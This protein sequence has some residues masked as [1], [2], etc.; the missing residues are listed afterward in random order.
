MTALTCEPWCLPTDIPARAAAQFVEQTDVA[1]CI[2][3]ASGIL[4]ALSGRRW[5]GSCTRTDLALHVGCACDRTLPTYADAMRVGFDSVTL[6]TND[7]SRRWVGL[8]LPDYPVTSVAALSRDGDPI[9]L[10]G[11]VLENNRDLMLLPFDRQWPV[12][13]Y[14]A[15]YDYGIAPPDEA[16][17]A[18]GVLAGEFGLSASGCE[19]R[20]PARVTSVTRQGI[21]A[22]VLD[23]LDFL[24]EGRTGIP[25]VDLFLSA[26]NPRSLSSR[27][28]VLSPDLLS[29]RQPRSLA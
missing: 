19:C 20:L 23:P 14:V 22:V 10:A 6:A 2:Q 12:G 4:Y 24:K 13:D 1:A 26:V 25:E 17:H 8:R 5:R 18:A 9:D 7:W 28:Q 29:P 11:V 16:R 3:L 27:P 21:T 15:T